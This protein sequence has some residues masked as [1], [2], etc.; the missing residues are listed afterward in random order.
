MRHRTGDG[1]RNAEG[2]ERAG[3]EYAEGH[4]ERPVN[5]LREEPDGDEDP[6]FL[7][8]WSLN[9]KSFCSPCQSAAAGSA[10]QGKP[11]S[12][13][14]LVLE[15]RTFQRGQTRS[16]ALSDFLSLS[17]LRRSGPGPLSGKM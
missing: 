1:R 17:L 7:R 12:Q 5:Q 14:G 13:I 3:G 6:Y 16:R 2:E 9:S 8:H 10:G 15:Q 4:S 11:I